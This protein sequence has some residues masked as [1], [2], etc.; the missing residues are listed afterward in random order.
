LAIPFV[1]WTTSIGM[2]H[3]FIVRFCISSRS[4]AKMV[5]FSCC[6]LLSLAYQRDSYLAA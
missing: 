2:C 6:V 1:S 3:T 5:L 4:I